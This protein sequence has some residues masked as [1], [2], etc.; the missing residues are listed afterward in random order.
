MPKRI[1]RRRTKG[2]RMPP[3]VVYVGRPTIFGNPFAW[4]GARESGYMGTE[5][6]LRRFSVQVFREWVTENHRF[7]HALATRY[8]IEA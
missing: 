6:E 4:Q 8:R 7:A 2:W 1:Q 5:D 3:G